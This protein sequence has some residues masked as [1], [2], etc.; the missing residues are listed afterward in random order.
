MYFRFIP[1][2]NHHP[3]TAVQHFPPDSSPRTTHTPHLILLSI[4]GKGKSGKLSTGGSSHPSPA[5]KMTSELK[6]DPTFQYKIKILLYDLTHISKDPA[7]ERRTSCTTDELYISAPYFSPDEASCAKS[8]LVDQGP[9][10]TGPDSTLEQSEQPQ[11]VSHAIQSRLTNFFE[12]R[13]ASG[14][15]RPCGPHDMAPIY[16]QVFGISKEELQDEKFLSRLRRQGLPSVTDGGAQTGPTRKG[17]R[18]G[19]RAKEK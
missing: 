8:A 3:N 11:T 7:S 10:H 15:T 5:P 14:D 1:G 19:G 13:R 2:S 17:T 6:A 16:L 12:K 9:R 4:M 18:P